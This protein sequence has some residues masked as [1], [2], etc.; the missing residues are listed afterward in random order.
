L[1]RQPYVKLWSRKELR[2]SKKLSGDQYSSWIRRKYGENIRA[3]ASNVGARFCKARPTEFFYAKN[4]YYYLSFCFVLI[5][6]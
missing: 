1:R 5:K 6:V 2:G 4:Y 3:D